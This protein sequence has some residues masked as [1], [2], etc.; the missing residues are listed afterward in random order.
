MVKAARRKANELTKQSVFDPLALASACHMS[1]VQRNKIWSHIIKNLSIDID[2]CDQSTSVPSI[3]KQHQQQQPVFHLRD[4]PMEQ[5][6]FSIKKADIRILKGDDTS[7]VAFT[8]KVVETIGN[9]RQDTT[10]LLIELQ[11]GNQVESV[12][13]RHRQYST[14]C[15]SSQIGCAMGCK[16]CATGTVSCLLSMHDL[17]TC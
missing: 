14:L 12:I 5:Q 9:S 11:D 10:K 2:D 16:F 6:T 1:N 8:S 15:V 13:I 7:F 4:V 3:P 17:Y